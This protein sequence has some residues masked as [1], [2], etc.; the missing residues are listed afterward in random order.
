MGNLPFDVGID[1]PNIPG[2]GRRPLS[3]SLY[4]FVALCLSGVVDPLQARARRREI[5]QSV[6]HRLNL[7][8]LTEPLRGSNNHCGLVQ[9]YGNGPPSR[10]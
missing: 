7:R 3:R 9:A 10:Y 1:A 8:E 4:F 5:F 6:A 2:R